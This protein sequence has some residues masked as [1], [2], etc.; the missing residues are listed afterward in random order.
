MSEIQPIGLLYIKL[1][2]NGNRPKLQI[3]GKTTKSIVKIEWLKIRSIIKIIVQNYNK[4][5]S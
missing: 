1:P 4:I 3:R 2:G 5:S